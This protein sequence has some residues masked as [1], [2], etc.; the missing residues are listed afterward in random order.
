MAQVLASLSA[1]ATAIIQPTGLAQVLGAPKAAL[2]DANPGG[3]AATQITGTV[4]QDFNSNGVMDT[5]GT[6]PNLSIDV[7][8]GGVTV[9]AYVTALTPGAP[10]ATATSAADGTYTLTGLTSGTQYRVEFTALPVGFFPAYH[11]SSG[12]PT[13]PS[14]DTSVQ[15]VEAGTSNVSF[16]IGHPADYCQ[17]NP[18]LCSNMYVNGDTNTTTPTDALLRFPYTASGTSPT[19]PVIATKAEIGAT[20]G[21]AYNR[22]SRVIYSAAFL[23]RHV[24]LGPNGLGAIYATDPNAATSSLFVDMTTLGVDV[25][26]SSVPSNAARGLGAPTAPNT[27][28][29]AFP[30]V[31]KVGLGDI[32][33]SD[34][35]NTLYVMSLNNKTLYAVD[36]ATK[37]LAG[38]FV[39]PD[40]GCTG[41]DWRPFALKYHRAGLYV[42]GVCDAETSQ[43]AAN[44]RAIVYRFDGATFTSVLNFPLNYQK[45]NPFINAGAC[46]TVTLWMPWR[47]TIPPACDSNATNTM[48]IYPTP[49]FSDLDVDV[50]GSLILGFADRMGHQ[51]GWANSDLAGSVAN[52]STTTS[53]D[54]LRAYNNNG[55]F[56]L[57]S[58][59]TAGPNTTLGAGNGEGPGG[60]EYYYQEFFPGY[61]LETSDGGLAQLPGSGEVVVTSMDPYGTA[62]GAGGIN[63]MNNRTGQALNSGYLFY[64]T[65][66]LNRETF[67]KAGGVG[68]VEVLCD[69][70]P[71]E[72]GNRVWRDTNNNGVQDADEAG[73]SGVQVSLQSPTGTIGTVNTAADGTYYFSG[74]QPNTTYTLTFPTTNGG[75]PLTTQNATG[76]SSNNPLTDLSDSDADAAGV[77]TFATGNAGENNHTLDVGYGIPLPTPTPTPTATPTETPTPTPT[78]TTVPPTATPTPTLT[79]T[80]TTVPPTATPTPTPTTIPQAELELVKTV[81]NPNPVVGDL[82]TYTLTLT[83]HGPDT[84]SGVQVRDLLPGG[85]TYQSSNPQQG[86]YTPNTGLWD[87]GT[88]AA[89]TSVTLTIT[90]RIQ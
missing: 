72:I 63:K 51:L 22:N 87:V 20:W 4:F 25:G 6:A 59:G 73:L 17:N 12:D 2:A 64:V 58:N 61:H 47:A 89:S 86:T 16:G 75:V 76:N 80:A 78:A 14:S 36:V 1:A 50:D 70:A 45:G 48:I 85:M 67:S 84:A 9:S 8:V 40:P 82:L 21:L 29:A 57:E 62:I 15:F 38:S 26:Q 24:G 74:L 39:V 13:T 49:L 66:G 19:P 43:S 53:G 79:P 56:V 37:A 69:S 11:G 41:G 34:D 90:V 81:D 10:V 55:T 5:T 60:G 27:D 54:I 65:V 68:D 52:L 3:A 83:N 46:Q 31:G 23:K 18:N 33:L 77:I 42:G 88:V 44:L 35:G 71:I 32:D 30:L 28:A 7:G